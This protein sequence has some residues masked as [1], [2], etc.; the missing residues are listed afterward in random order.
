MR[1]MGDLVQL[2][3]FTYAMCWQPGKDEH[4]PAA[5][6]Q[7]QEHRQILEAA[8]QPADLRDAAKDARHSEKQLLPMLGQTP[9]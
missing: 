7:P 9:T 1:K 3:S 8:A 4:V 5:L 6:T 2:G